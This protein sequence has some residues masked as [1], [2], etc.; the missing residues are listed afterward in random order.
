MDYSDGTGL[1]AKVDKSNR[2]ATVS[3]K[4]SVDNKNDT[5][6]ATITFLFLFTFLFYKLKLVY[7]TSFNRV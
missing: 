7:S 5:D 1:I 4:T 3:A 2:Y 6:N